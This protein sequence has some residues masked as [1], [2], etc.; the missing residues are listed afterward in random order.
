MIKKTILTAL[1]LVVAYSVF[2][3]VVKPAWEITDHQA[4][5]NLVLAQ[6]FIYNDNA[7]IRNV[8]VGSSLPCRLVLEQVKNTYNLSFGGHGSI[9]GL[10]L[11]DSRKQLPENIL[12]EMNSA[13]LTENK[14]F[15]STLL[16]RLSY[17]WWKLLP[18]LRREK[19]PI[20]FLGAFLS[21]RGT[22]FFIDRFKSFL[23]LNRENPGSRNAVFQNML[24]MQVEAYSKNPD[25]VLVRDCFNNLQKHLSSLEKRGANI[26]FFEMPI[27]KKLC[28]LPWPKTIRENYHVCFPPD[29]YKYIPMPDCA[30]YTTTDGVHLVGEEALKYTNYFKTQLSK[31]NINL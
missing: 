30:E 21:V 7:A 11:I 9:D 20:G 3:A 19:Q 25:P 6:K 10:V 14:A 23:S 1:C 29:K 24:D 27:H 5:A 12:V 22:D 2:V 15:T 17:H 16:S 26:I 8:I 4:Q 18:A 31:Y 13:L 28:D